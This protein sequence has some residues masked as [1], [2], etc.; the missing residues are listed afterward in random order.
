MSEQ[1]YAKHLQ[2]FDSITSLNDQHGKSSTQFTDQELLLKI[3]TDNSVSSHTSNADKVTCRLSRARLF[4][5]SRLHSRKK[6]GREPSRIP[7]RKVIKFF[8]KTRLIR[9]AAKSYIKKCIPSS[10]LLKLVLSKANRCYFSERLAKSKCLLSSKKYF[11]RQN[12]YLSFVQL[13]TLKHKKSSLFGMYVDAR[14]LK[15]FKHHQLQTY[16]LSHRVISL[17]GDVEENPRPS[18]QCSTNTQLATQVASA[19]NSFPLPETRL[20]ELNRIALDVG[21]GCD[22]FFR[23]VSH[24]LN[25]NPD[26]HFHVNNL[27]IQHLMHNPEQL[28]ESNTEHSWQ[29]YLSKMSCQGTWADA[30]IIQAVA[31]CLNLSIHFAESNETFNPVTI[32]QPMNV[33][34]ECTKIYIF[35]HIGETHYMSTVEN[36]SSD[37]PKLKRRG[38]G[39]TLIEDKLI[40]GKEK[41]GAYKKEYIKKERADAEY[42]K[43]ENIYS[44]QRYNN[45]ETIREKKKKAVTERKMTS[46]EH[47]R[48]INKQSKRKRKVE[49]PE[50]MKEISK[51]FLTKW[52]AENPE[53][54][55][56]TNNHSFKKRKVKNSEPISQIKRNYA[57]VKK[58]VMSVH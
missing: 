15:K 25:G 34:S 32:V 44:K 8:G 20:S 4:S 28:I 7:Y 19:S 16:H 40:D 47:V 43:K 36:S 17:S 27:G 41:H 10:S 37:L 52:K 46:L 26:N 30:I 14:M 51:R 35:V 6:R 55:K 42:R 57:E 33:T 31:N 11:V 24:Q 49:N 45:I 1:I 53:Y 50:H 5:T 18:N 13:R 38:Q 3:P 29:A 2:R 39:Q 21:G 23:A 9:D 48:E 22:C 54:R 56:K 58:T 12:F